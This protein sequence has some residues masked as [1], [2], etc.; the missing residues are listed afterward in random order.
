M[1]AR[2]SCSAIHVARS[3]GSGRCLETICESGRL[4]KY[5]IT[6]K[7]NP[8]YL[9]IRCVW[10]MF[11][12][13]IFAEVSASFVNRLRARPSLNTDGRITLIATSR[14]SVTCFARN[15][16]P[17]APTPMCLRIL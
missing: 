12:W 9:I 4:G 16:E 10:M 11:G 13:F 3:H 15:T 17:I 5:S 1:S 14:F 6:R 8:L 2:A 7:K